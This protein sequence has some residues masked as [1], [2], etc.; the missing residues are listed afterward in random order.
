MPHLEAL[1]G[2]LLQAGVAAKDLSGQRAPQSS[3]VMQPSQ[4]LQARQQCQPVLGQASPQPSSSTRMCYM[5]SVAAAEQALVWDTAPRILAQL[6][7]MSSLA[8]AT[9]S[10]ATEQAADTVHTICAFSAV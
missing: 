3:G 8:Q 9:T 2:S 5:R 10:P 7:F 4:V 1:E 6:T